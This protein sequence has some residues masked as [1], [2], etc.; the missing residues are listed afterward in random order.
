MLELKES[1]LSGNRRDSGR[2]L[3]GFYGV[4]RKNPK[5]P[6]FFRVIR[7]PAVVWRGVQKKFC[8]GSSQRTN[9][10]EALVAERVDY[11]KIK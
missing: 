8:H 5:K 3:D 7:F 11:E 10:M 2:G 9:S 4:T 6:V 1:W